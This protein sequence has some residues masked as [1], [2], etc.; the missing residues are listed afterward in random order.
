MISSYKELKFYIKA[1]E[2][3]NDF[4]QPWYKTIAHVNI[5]KRWLKTYR[6]VEWL[7][8]GKQNHKWMILPYIY[9]SRKLDKLSYL[10]GYSIPLG[11][12]GYG[13]FLAH[14]GTCVIN[15]RN[16]IGNYSCVF[17]NVCI[18]DG[19]IKELGIGVFYGTGTVVAKTVTIGNGC[20]V[21]ANS[22]VNKSYPDNSLIG[23]APSKL[24]R[25][26]ITP[27]FHEEPY[28]SRYK[29]IESLRK[30]FGL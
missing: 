26:N 17:N 23:G 12:L 8:Y 27:W 2:I 21:S 1:D 7:F 3:M 6:I 25:E 20:K 29:E 10:C 13:I 28:F 18:A 15:G 9:Y 4:C 30:N 11:C 24:L 22:F 5:R 14:H 16:R 19:N